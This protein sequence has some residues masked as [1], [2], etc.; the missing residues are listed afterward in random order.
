MRKMHG[1]DPRG[2]MARQAETKMGRGG[3]WSERN[4]EIEGI[5]RRKL[6]LV[7]HNICPHSPFPSLDLYI[8]PP[9]L[10]S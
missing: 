5:M 3:I 7:L 8:V 6:V 10:T 9:A 4:L 1:A 2:E